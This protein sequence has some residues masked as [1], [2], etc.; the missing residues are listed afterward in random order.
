MVFNMLKTHKKMLNMDF[1][2]DVEMKGVFFYWKNPEYWKQW[3]FIIFY[4]L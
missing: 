1:N 2:E 4:S 3:S